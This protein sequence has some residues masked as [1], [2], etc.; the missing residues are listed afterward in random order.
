MLY[1]GGMMNEEE[2]EYHRGVLVRRGR[3]GIEQ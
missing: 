3:Y 1:D 2:D